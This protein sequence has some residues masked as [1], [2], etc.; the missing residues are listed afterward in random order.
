MKRCALS[1]KATESTLSPPVANHVWPLEDDEKLMPGVDLVTEVDILD[2]FGLI[3]TGTPTHDET[4][5][6]ADPKKPASY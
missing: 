6:P 1:A 5:L 4:A 3:N 2:L